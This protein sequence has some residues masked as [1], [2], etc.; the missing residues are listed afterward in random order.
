MWSIIACKVYATYKKTKIFDIPSTF[1][2]SSFNSFST[3]KCFVLFELVLLLK[4]NSLLS[5]SVLFTKLAT[6]LSQQ[7]HSSTV[8]C[9]ELTKFWT[10]Y[11]FVTLIMISNFSFN[12]INFCVVV[13]FFWTRLL[14]LG[15]LFQTV[16][17]AAVKATLVILSISPLTSS[18]LVISG[19][20][21]LIFFFLALYALF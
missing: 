3:S 8:L 1:F 7:Y 15:I 13:S 17:R 6:S 19:I 18:I 9:C 16:A 14:T 10:R 20:L 2:D 11:I 21:S 12:F 5:K 4:F